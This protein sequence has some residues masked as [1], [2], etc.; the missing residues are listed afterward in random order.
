MP[1]AYAV[2]PAPRANQRIT[3]SSNQHHE[4]P[5]SSRA[6]SPPPH[7][8]EEAAGATSRP[9]SAKRK[10]KKLSSSHR[11]LT[12]DH[13][14]K[15]TND[16]RRRHDSTG[17]PVSSHRKKHHHERHN[18]GVAL[19]TA[20]DRKKSHKSE[21]RTEHRRS[22][23]KRKQPRSN[24]DQYYDFDEVAQSRERI[25]T[26]TY[27]PPKVQSSSGG[28][29]WSCSSEST[30]ASSSSEERGPPP[31][32]VY[33]AKGG[34]GGIDT[35]SHLTLDSGTAE[36]HRSSPRSSKH[37]RFHHRD[38]R[39]PSPKH[40]ANLNQWY[41]SRSPTVVKTLTMNLSHSDDDLHTLPTFSSDEGAL[42][43][44][45]DLP[46]ITKADRGRVRTR[47][48]IAFMAIFVTIVQ[49][50]VLML[51]TAL[52]GTANW[53]INPMIGP[54]P[55][56]FS[57]WGG[58][59]PYLMLHDNQWWRL[60]T[61][62]F[63]HVGFLHFLANAF[64]QLE[65]IALFER[66]WGSFKWALIY[67]VSSI[68]CNT[69]SSFFDSNTIA[70]GSSGALMGLYAA[71]LAQV[72]S[73]VFFDVTIS[74]VDDSIRLDQLSS[75]LCGLTIVSLLSSFTYID[76]SGHMG[77]LFAGFL[78]G[79]VLFSYS[80]RRCCAW[81]LWS[82]LGLLGLVA[83]FTSVLYFFITTVQPYEELAD[84]CEYFRSL[85]PEG[86]DCGCMWG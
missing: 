19:P 53:D 21:R 43:G 13:E 79:M 40:R 48:S 66:E 31:T 2:P 82:A 76:W 22:D 65:A 7:P 8:D 75:V 83:L 47:Q 12:V 26:T 81:F 14:E 25:K 61:P 55:D 54:Y 80:I 58:K 30:D 3:R 29:D 60:F 15:R 45:A 5:P 56:A 49:L 16:G 36:L 20:E 11:H 50:L 9:S 78:T 10:T 41:E 70:V 86:Y 42:L 72:C 46:N 1:P 35:E 71:K 38:I 23:E 57:E 77:G 18:H 59:N 52:C 67:I 17:R 4:K 85:F 28:Q 74:A 73:A 24:H 37:K 44:A 32:R 6:T 68:G 69:V 63:L 34:T 33:L 64:C 27:Q 62:S 39:N 51:Q 84:P